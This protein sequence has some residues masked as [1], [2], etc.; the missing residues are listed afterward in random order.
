MFETQKGE[1]DLKDQPRRKRSG[2]FRFR[3]GFGAYICCLR[4]R[5]AYSQDK[6]DEKRL[7]K[8]EIGF[9]DAI[10]TKFA[11]EKRAIKNWQKIHV[12]LIFLVSLKIGHRQVVN[13]YNCKAELKD[14]K[15]NWFTT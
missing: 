8:S 11:Q 2:C 10:S 13:G 1:Q 9:E 6:A 3:Y 7:M 5:Y 12:R 14:A 4:T 15:E